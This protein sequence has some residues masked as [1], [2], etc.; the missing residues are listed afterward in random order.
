MDDPLHPPIRPKVT[1]KKARS[2]RSPT[3]KML[4]RKAKM[5][6]Q[7]NNSDSDEDGKNV[8][9]TSADMADQVREE[10]TLILE[11]RQILDEDSDDDDDSYL[12]WEMMEAEKKEKER[13]EAEEKEEK[14]R[15]VKERAMEKSNSKEKEEG[16]TPPKEVF[17]KLQE[18]DADP[19]SVSDL[20][21][22]EDAP[23]PVDLMAALSNARAAVET[24]KVNA[25]S[26][27]SNSAEIKE[28]EE[29]DAED[30]EEEEKEAKEEEEEEEDR[31]GF[32][33][34]SI[35]QKTV[36]IPKNYMELQMAFASS[37][38]R[39][40]ASLVCER[41]NGKSISPSETTFSPN[42][43]IVFREY[44]SEVR[45]DK[46]EKK[47]RGM[48]KGWEEDVYEKELEGFKLR[49]WQEY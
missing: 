33:Y 42:E 12:F 4:E 5:L 40:D 17:I 28:P 24:Q 6:A 45:R 22:V 46:Q 16:Q 49:T 25:E 18:P 39:H 13:L 10:G 34:K 32:G 11:L 30:G 44:M 41:L 9:K 20:G 14:K 8:I 47:V 48:G 27:F 1:P 19:P 3:K 23:V 15:R 37:W 29:K 36:P 35:E 38:P 21:G 2:A 31:F 43:V 7:E 26:I